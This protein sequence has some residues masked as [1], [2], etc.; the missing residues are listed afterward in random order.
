MFSICLRFSLPKSPFLSICLF[1]QLIN[2]ARYLFREPCVLL[3]ARYKD[4]SLQCPAKKVEV[5]CGRKP[6]LPGSSRPRTVLD[7]TDALRYHLCF[8]Y[9]FRVI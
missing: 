7:L 1:L 4:G 8:Y 2:F 5:I 6:R 9:S 3:S